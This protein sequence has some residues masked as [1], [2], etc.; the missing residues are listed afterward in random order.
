MLTHL[1]KGAQKKIVLGPTMKRIL[2][3]ILFIY[4]STN[5]QDVATRAVISVEQTYPKL[6]WIFG[7]TETF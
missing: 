6:T 4:M 5:L 3:S 2:R 1:K 7:I